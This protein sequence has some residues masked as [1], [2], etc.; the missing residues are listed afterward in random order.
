MDTTYLAKER[1]VPVKNDVSPIYGKVVDRPRPSPIVSIPR[2]A[3][4]GSVEVSWQ[5]LDRRVLVLIQPKACPC[6]VADL[7]AVVVN[8]DV[9]TSVLIVLVLDLAHDV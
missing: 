2:T 3:A 6:R 8:D 7:Q 5:A 9:S 4:V 1:P